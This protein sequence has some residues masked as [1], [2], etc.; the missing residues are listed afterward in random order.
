MRNHICLKRSDIV[1]C[2]IWGFG[3]TVVVDGGVNGVGS[4]LI[5][6]AGGGANDVELVVIVGGGADGVESVSGNW[7]W[8][9]S[10]EYAGLIKPSVLFTVNEAFDADF[11]RSGLNWR[12]FRFDKRYSSLGGLN[13]VATSLDWF[14]ESE[15]NP[16]KS[17]DKAGVGE[18]ELSIEM[19][20]M[21]SSRTSE[22]SK[23]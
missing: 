13:D 1:R 4:V 15:S 21:L 19:L 3:E 12:N 20:V 9:D 11:S 2:G 5:E 16:D 6:G 17:L 10:V 23:Y 7:L 22:G 8:S 18:H 14:F